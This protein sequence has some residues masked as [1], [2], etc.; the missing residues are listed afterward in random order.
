VARVVPV[1]V[2]AS[3]VPGETFTLEPASR[4]VVRSGGP[5]ATRVADLLA[6]LL[7][8]PTGFRLPVTGEPS[9]SGHDVA[10]ELA[11]PESLG[12]EGYELTV[13]DQGATLRART[14]EGLFRAVQTFRQLLPARIEGAEAGP[15][16]WPVAG[17]KI[18]DHPRFERR[19]LMLDVARHFFTVAEVERLVDLAALYK[20]NVLHLHL[21]DDQGWRIAIDG[22]PRLTEVGGSTAVGGGQGG[23]YTQED[24]RAIVAYAADRFVTVVPEIDAPGHVNAALA[25]YPELSCDGAAPP[26][27]TGIGVGFSSLCAGKEVTYRFLDDVIGQLAALT[28]GLYIH[29]GGDEANSTS[30]KDY[31]AFVERAQ[32]IVAA[33]GKRLLGWE[34][35]AGAPLPKTA[36]AQF[37]ATPDDARA[38][39]AQGVRVVMSPSRHAYLDMKY[40]DA[41]PLGQKWAGLIEVS[42]AYDWDPAT[43][44]DGVA[45]RDVAGVE[46]PIW[47]ETLV[48]SADLDFMTYPRLPAI[49]EVGWSPQRS[50]SWA[51][52][53]LRLAEQAPRWTALGVRFYRSPQVPWGQ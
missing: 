37:W 33:H 47:T 17:V 1:P 8:R 21:S 45:A 23:F 42:D 41:T 24:Y 34:Q 3:A 20:L 15:G 26:L 12:S 10:L 6:G 30:Q 5:P 52:F 48:T 14:P 29:L 9:G 38:A 25:S 22:W 16:P 7:R 40:T 32:R 13:L 19:G 39:V 2:S 31:V 35:L 36:L 18:V 46:A 4:I 11:G 28:P 44:V 49:A 53:R 51:D 27:Y 50:R 43:L